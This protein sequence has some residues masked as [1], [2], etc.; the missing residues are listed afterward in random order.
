MS[1]APWEIVEADTIG[2]SSKA[3]II[4]SGAYSALFHRG[5]VGAA[6]FAQC[7]PTVNTW[8]KV[9]QPGVPFYDFG[10]EIKRVIQCFFRWLLTWVLFVAMFSDMCT[11]EAGAFVEREKWFTCSEGGGKLRV[12]QKE[13]FLV[14]PWPWTSWLQCISVLPSLG[15]GKHPCRFIINFPLLLWTG[16]GITLN[17]KTPNWQKRYFSL[18]ILD[19]KHFHIKD[20]IWIQAHY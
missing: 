12:M 13:S 18:Q 17:Q 19:L 6:M 1:L 5:R 16:W 3:V 11:C 4:S 8:S 20:T 9:G 2:L 15:S 14:S 10:N 7:G